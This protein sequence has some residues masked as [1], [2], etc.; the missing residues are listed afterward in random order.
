MKRQAI[1]SYGGVAV[2]I[3]VLLISV[4]FGR[5]W[6]ASRPAHL[7]LGERALEVC[8]QQRQELK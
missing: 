7:T 4:V 5:M 8:F 6:S 3:H 2:E 1:K